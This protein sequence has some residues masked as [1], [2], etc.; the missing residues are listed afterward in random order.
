MPRTDA[1]CVCWSRIL[2]LCVLSGGLCEDEEFGSC[3]TGWWQEWPVGWR[4][5][6]QED[7]MAL[8]MTHMQPFLGCDNSERPRVLLVTTQ[9]TREAKH[10]ER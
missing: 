7:D 3:E 2:S 1:R 9:A 5:P 10:A 6:D 8:R 4:E